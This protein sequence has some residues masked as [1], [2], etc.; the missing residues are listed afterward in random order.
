M[1]FTCEV[2]KQTFSRCAYIN[3]C[4]QSNC[5]PKSNPK[6]GLSHNEKLVSIKIQQ[7]TPTS[8]PAPCN[9]DDLPKHLENG[10]SH[11]EKLVSRNIQQ[12]TP[13][14]EPS[15]SNKDDSPTHLE[16]GALF[17]VVSL[18]KKTSSS[19]STEVT[20]KTQDDSN[21]SLSNIFLEDGANQSNG[22]EIESILQD[23]I[24]DIEENILNMISG[25][26]DPQ[27]LDGVME[28][29][30]EQLNENVGNEEI[31]GGVGL[32][33]QQENSE[34]NPIVFTENNEEIQI[35][36]NIENEGFQINQAEPPKGFTK[37]GNPR[38]RAAPRKKEEIKSKRQRNKE[39][40]NIQP[41]CSDNC[42]RKCI[43]KV[44][45]ERRCEIHEH[46][47]SMEDNERKVF[48][49]GHVEKKK[50]VRNTKDEDNSR[51]GK[52][53][54][55]HLTNSEGERKNVCKTFFLTTLGYK[56]KNDMFVFN[57]LNRSISG[58]SPN[59]DK[60]GRH[61]PHNFIDKTIIKDH[62]LK[63][64]PCI[65]HY[66]REHAPN[67]KY[68]PAEL[69]ITE[70]HNAFLEEHEGI[71]CS[72]DLY[73]SVLLEMNVSFSKLGHEE[74]EK[75]TSYKLHNPQHVQEND[76]S[77]LE[78]TEWLA[79][80]KKY[81][82][83]RMSYGEY[84]DENR[85]NEYSNDG[86]VVCSMDLQKVLMLPHM[87]Q[88]KQ[89]VFTK[90]IVLFNESF[91]PIGKKPKIEPMACL[92][93][94]AISGRKK[95][96]ITSALHAFLFHYRDAKEIHL[97]MDN[98]ASQNK[99]WSLFSYMVGLIN[100]S[101]IASNKI[102]FN[103]LEPGHT[104]MSADQFHHQVNQQIKTKGKVYDFDDFQ[105]AVMKSNSGK[106][107]V[108]SLQHTDFFNSFDYSS[109]Y[110]I[111]NKIPR[112]YLSEMVQ[113]IFQR[114]SFDIQYKTSFISE[115]IE[116]ISIL[117]AGYLKKKQVPMPTRRS[118]PRGINQAKKADII[119]KLLPLMPENRR[120]FWLDLPASSDVPDLVTDQEVE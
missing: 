25:T 117:K 65:S 21:T 3:H 87:E 71:V 83:A 76:E 26:L 49:L 115:Q 58:V 105:D 48:I 51:R 114:G 103:Y 34:N 50:V 91:V 2:C 14:S 97:W 4:A 16:N 112:P 28:L 41:P 12:L 82:E 80:K 33:I 44:S 43:Q 62:I 6:I 31:L 56:K 81:T 100:C 39:K 54:F 110:K 73:R 90:R 5:R 11:D 7:R 10:L 22:C 37:K 108:K 61:T 40:H 1:P 66:R 79:H 104:F 57:V 99:N 46:F 19:S 78:C 93:H 27:I 94:E 32:L 107:I 95:E 24:S 23:N 55:Y 119:Q 68:L 118:N 88:F 13:T 63:Y 86:I 8:E 109:T 29:E 30:H 89:A 67:R 92:W 96:D 18:D 72:Y 52:T 74:C 36:E 9:K 35:E 15:P 84:I 106:V 116:S 120:S 20:E 45:E 98:C 38:K 75:C 64:N 60:R 102:V 42:K 17:M 111:T 77:C 101:E 69:S 70:M 85:L 47:W 59:C 113:V 53:F